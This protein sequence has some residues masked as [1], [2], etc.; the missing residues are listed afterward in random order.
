VELKPNDPVALYGVTQGTVRWAPNDTYNQALDNKPEYAGRV[1]QVGPVILPIRGTT[2]S[3]Y[4]PSQA[5][6]SRSM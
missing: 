3:Y 5:R 2:Q 4:T 1:R 6:S